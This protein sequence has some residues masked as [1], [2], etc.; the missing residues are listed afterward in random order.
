MFLVTCTVAYPSQYEGTMTL[1]EEA[2]DQS[3][4]TEDGA[5]VLRKPH[6][7][8]PHSIFPHKSCLGAGTMHTDLNPKQVCHFWT[9]C[10]QLE[11][12]VCIVAVCRPLSPAGANPDAFQIGQGVGN[13]IG[14]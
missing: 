11:F 5:S 8:A 9:S 12:S 13:G 7:L 6:V 2:A 14:P 1:C 10:R 4:V 3:A